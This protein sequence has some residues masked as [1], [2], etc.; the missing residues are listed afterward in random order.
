MKIAL[1]IY[2]E[3]TLA[4]EYIYLSSAPLWYSQLIGQLLLGTGLYFIA[5]H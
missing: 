2:M 4:I 1:Y 5:S 3:D